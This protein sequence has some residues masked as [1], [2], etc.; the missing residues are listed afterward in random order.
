MIPYI[1][2]I[3]NSVNSSR[4]KQIDHFKEYPAETQNKVF[5]RLVETASGTEWG[6][7]YDYSSLASPREFSKRVPLQTYEDLLP[8]IDRIGN[9]EADL[10]W[11]GKIRW[12]AKSSG[13]TSSKSKFIPMSREALFETQYRAV[14]DLLAIYIRNNPHTRIFPGK[15]LTL[16]GSHRIDQFG[17]RALCG[18]LSAIMIENTPLYAEIVRTPNKKIALT[19]DF[20]KKLELITK[21]TVNRNVTSFSG[22]PSW[23]LSLIKHIL[24]YTGKSNLLE[25]WPNLEVFF[26]GGI[27]FNPYRETYNQLIPDSRM[28]YMETYNASEGFFAIQEDPASDD[29]L[30]MLDYG[31]YYEFIPADRFRYPDPPAYNIAEVGKGIN[32]VMI[33]STSGGLWRYVM[34]DTVV[35]TNLNPHR[36][37]ITGRTKYFI[38]AFGEEVIKENAEEAL[39]KAC[40][41][42]AAVISE[43]TAGPVYMG[44]ASKGSHEWI[45]EFEKEPSDI[46]LFI[47]TLDETLKSV[48]SDYEAK[49]YKDINLVMPVIRSVPAG[50]F[51]K[52]MKSRNK[53]GGQNKVPRLSNGR[54]YIEELYKF[55]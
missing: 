14:K 15:S 50:T 36:I 28:Q 44:T 27:N 35:F 22:T 12:F 40:L 20:E 25:V 10:L 48:N 19:D 45:I 51:H 7:K 18:D 47:Y 34:G 53:L 39:R 21:A 23:Y 52:W 32:Y 26:H 8:Y 3:F 41:S 43:Y 2:T 30:L 31:I 29:M 38:N 9:G 55:L 11:P 4:L 13:T 16:G 46:N 1:S 5:S 37:R 42:T 17:S 54:E 24:A 6:R 49:R 33:I